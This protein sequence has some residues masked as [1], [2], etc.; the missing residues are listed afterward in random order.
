MLVFVIPVKNREIAKSWRLLSVLLERTLRSICN[1][2]SQNFRVIVVCNEKPDVNF[3]HP[4]IEYVEVDF[5]PPITGKEQSALMK[6]GY[7]GGH[8]IVNQDRDKARRILAGLDYAKK[9]N[10]SYSMVVDADDCVNCRLTEFVERHPQTLGWLLKRGYVYPEG[11]RLLFLNTRTFYLTCGT[12]VIIDYS[13]RH[14]LFTNPNFY[15]HCLKSPLPQL[16]LKPL[17]FVGAVYS[18]TNGENIYMNLERRSA[19]ETGI[20]SRIFS[21]DIF[22]SIS[23]IIKYRPMLLTQ[24]VRSNFGL[25][26][27]DTAPDQ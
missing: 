16:A 19:I 4:H 1:Q 2:T 6:H 5:P 20:F 9:F 21:R 8:I 15:N 22:V 11:S 13:Q 12:S 10:P 27:I 24:A 7:D 3:S 26:N 14:L 25:Y 23:K 17:P 18:M